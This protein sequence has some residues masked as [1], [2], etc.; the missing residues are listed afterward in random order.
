MQ[1]VY[2]DGEISTID[3]RIDNL[4]FLDLKDVPGAYVGQVGNVVVVN[5]TGD[6]LAFK[7]IKSYEPLTDGD[8]DNPDFI[9]GS[10]DILMGVMV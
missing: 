2:T 6:G 9:F 5:N 1:R 4:T 7:S 10:G 8:L 3:T